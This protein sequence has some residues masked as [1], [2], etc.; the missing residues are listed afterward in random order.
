MQKEI[1]ANSKTNHPL[2][3]GIK[4]SETFLRMKIWKK[5]ACFSVY[6]CVKWTLTESYNCIPTS[7]LWYNFGCKT[8]ITLKSQSVGNAELQHQ[9]NNT[10]NTRHRSTNRTNNSSYCRTIVE[11]GKQFRGRCSSRGGSQ[12]SNSPGHKRE[13]D[14]SPDLERH[15]GVGSSQSL[16][17]ASTVGGE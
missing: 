12:V 2:E 11:T 14:N 9:Q 16:S 15:H 13:R 5:I 3:T 8:S 10:S 4:I 1:S 7:L 17:S 6:L